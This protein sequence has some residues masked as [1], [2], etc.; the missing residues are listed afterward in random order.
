MKQKLAIV[1]YLAAPS[2]FFSEKFW[3]ASLVPC[4]KDLG[5]HFL[6]LVIVK[7][8]RD[9]PFF[10]IFFVVAVAN[11][12]LPYNLSFPSFVVFLLFM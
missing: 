6:L 5:S 9:C 4:L 3:L 1:T 2:V 11:C 12:F 10:L 8:V 7:P